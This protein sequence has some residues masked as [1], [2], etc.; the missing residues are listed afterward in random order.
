[1][2]RRVVAVS[3]MALVGLGLIYGRLSNSMIGNV[4]PDDHPILRALDTLGAISSTDMAFRGVD[5]VCIVNEVDIT[6]SGS[7][8]CKTT[9]EVLALIRSG[10]CDIIPLEKL[11]VRV[12][13]SENTFECKKTDAGFRMAIHKSN[14]SEILVFD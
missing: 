13:F 3:L 8:N 11:R 1:M 4:T 2:K 9:G 10:G 14:E 6:E 7:R 12:L 5:E